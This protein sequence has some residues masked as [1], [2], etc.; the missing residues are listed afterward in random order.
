MPQ[1]ALP[2]CASGLNGSRQFRQFGYECRKTTEIVEVVRVHWVWVEVHDGV[3]D[4]ANAVGSFD[5]LSSVDLEPE[6]LPTITAFEQSDTQEAV[7]SETLGFDCCR[8]T[9]SRSVILSK[10]RLVLRPSALV[11][12]S[13]IFLHRWLG[14]GLAVL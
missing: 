9:R 13:L 1:E 12:A 10:E 7:I 6:L 2:L 4:H 14:V 8:G 3:S 11:K 5:E